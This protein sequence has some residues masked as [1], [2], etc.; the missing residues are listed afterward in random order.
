MVRKRKVDQQVKADAPDAEAELFCRTKDRG[1]LLVAGVSLIVI[2]AFTWV[3]WMWQ[4]P[5]TKNAPAAAAPAP[6]ET[7]LMSALVSRFGA[8]RT[9]EEVLPLVREPARFDAPVR[10]WFAA[11][12]PGP[13]AKDATFLRTASRRTAFGFNLCQVVVRD[14]N[15]PLL[16]VETPAGWRVEWRAFAAE[17]DLSVE[18]F[19]AK[20]PAEPVL[21]LAV[22]QRSSYYNEPYN[23]S[24]KWQS[25]YL[26]GGLGREG[27][28]GYLSASG[29]A[30]LLQKV[31]ALPLPPGDGRDL[32]RTSR[33]FAL[34]LRFASPDAAGFRLAEIVSIEGDGWFIP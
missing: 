30:A 12:P 16:L 33:R 13:V 5:E 17:G 20:K 3:L 8:A 19:L 23:S 21:I 10:K 6:D 27:L 22:A 9:P 4:R 25:L 29:D 34:R 18:E 14:W 31:K 26:T 24:E 7:E 2:L 28:H 1:W 11:R 32:I 15:E